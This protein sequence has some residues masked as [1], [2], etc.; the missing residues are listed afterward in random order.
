[1]IMK[2]EKDKP[3]IE[4]LSKIEINNV[5]NGNMKDKDK[6]TKGDID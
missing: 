1:M 5:D 6:L 2:E 4:K 3:I